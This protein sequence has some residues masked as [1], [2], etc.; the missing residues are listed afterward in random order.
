MRHDAL[1]RAAALQDIRLEGFRI[2]PNMRAYIKLRRGN[3]R[4]GP[5]EV[6]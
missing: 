1:G 6:I 3:L 4:G 5:V 2:A